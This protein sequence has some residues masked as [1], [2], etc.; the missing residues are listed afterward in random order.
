MITAFNFCIA[1]KSKKEIDSL[2]KLCTISVTEPD[3]VDALNN[4]ANYFCTNKLYKQADSVLT[5]QLHIAE[6]SNNNSLILKTY[7]DNYISGIS[8][9][10][11]KEDFDRASDFIQRGID[12]SK[13]INSK[14]INTNDYVALGYT[15][16]ACILRKRGEKDKALENAN[17]A[18]MNIQ[19]I[20]SDSVKALVY[21]ELGDTYQSKGNSVQA[22]KNYNTA[23]DI[24][25]K[26]KNYHLE[27]DIYHRLADLYYLLGDQVEA[28]NN[29]LKS[30]G[31]NKKL[32]YGEGLINDYTSL[33]RVTNEIY[34]INLS[35]ALADSLHIDKYKVRAKNILL[36]IYTTK[37]KDSKR[38][39]D[40]L[41][42]QADLKDFYMQGGL[43][44]YYFELG[45]IYRFG[46]NMDSALQYFTL[47]ETDLF[48][49]F[50]PDKA[51]YVY[52]EMA[53]CYGARNDNSNAITYYEKALKYCTGLVNLTYVE[54]ISDSLFQLYQLQGDFK[55]A[56]NYKIV[57]TATKDTLLQLSKDKDIALLGVDRENRKHDE[58]V[59]QEEERSKNQRNIQYMFITIA[60][61]IVF[62]SMLVIGMFAV[63]KLV[64]KILGYF[65]FISLFEFIV[66]LLDNTFLNN[67]THGQPLKLWLI[68]IGLIGLLV[69]LQHFLESNLIKFL[70]SRKLLE[71]RTRFSFS[72][73]WHRVK[74]QADNPEIEIEKDVAVL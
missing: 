71:A 48:K 7:F 57:A 60:I 32:N 19:N 64:I 8:A 50:D 65:F 66:M 42:S 56:L 12:F 55:K 2:C 61:S 3:K 59:L 44:N 28:K 27:S 70:E 20:Q 30:V 33:G 62:L 21:L 37:L 45:E 31:V 73:W 41:N 51:K 5:E 15:R 1:Q 10:S 63:S 24:S 40:Y 25:L 47:A 49:T 46:N 69:P 16:L 29:L 14:S 6:L 53:A 58:E 74:K 26:S 68:K 52:S 43:G 22:C 11:T 72:K 4:L 34:Y 9:W 35:L 38:T 17:M 39:L 23:F 13:S 54:S 67:A 18:L 36:A